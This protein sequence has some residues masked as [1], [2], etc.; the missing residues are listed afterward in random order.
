MSIEA[1]CEGCPMAIEC[2]GQ[3]AAIDSTEQ[4]LEHGVAINESL[5]QHFEE[6]N[7]GGA[8]A[9]L[10][11]ELNADQLEAMEQRTD[12]F[13]LEYFGESRQDSYQ[14]SLDR[15]EQGFKEVEE[16]KEALGLV[17]GALSLDGARCKGPKVG[18]L[19]R[20]RDFIERVRQRFESPHMPKEW[21]EERLRELQDHQATRRIT[22]NAQDCGNKRAVKQYKKFEGTAFAKRIKESVL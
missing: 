22:Y 20:M 5:R 13:W 15:L 16:A 11:G 6:A 3:R 19:T 9:I 18:V 2:A 1:A 10:A 21:R 12:R 8:L 4:S 17:V 14:H 7:I